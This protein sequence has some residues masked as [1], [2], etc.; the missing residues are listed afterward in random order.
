MRFYPFV[1]TGEVP[2]KEVRT[3]LNSITFNEERDEETCYGYCNDYQPHAVK[4][5]FDYNNGMLYDMRW[6]DAGNLGQVSIAKLGDMF[7]AGRFLFWTEDSRMHTAIDEKFYSYYTYDHSGG[8][9]ASREQSQACLSY[10]EMEQR[11]RS[12]RRLKLVGDNCSM[13]VNAEYM[14]ASSALNEPTFYPSA[15]MVLTNKGYT[16]H[17]YAGTER[18]AARLGGGGLY[19][20][21]PVIGND[22]ELQKKADILF[23][24]SI[25]QVNSRVLGENDLD[26]IMHNEYA[27]AEFGKWIEG[28]PYQVRA[29]VETEYWQFKDMVHSMLVDLNNGQEKEVYF[30]HS[31]H[32]GSASWIT[33]G[34]G[35]AVQ[36]IQYLPYGEPYI[37]QRAAG[38]T[39]S[40][41][42]R[43][44]G[45]ERDEET[46]YGYFGA[47]YM[48]HELMTM[49]LSVDPMADKYHSISPYAYCAWN[50]VKLVDPD[51]KEMTDFK[52]KKGNL[53]KHFEDGQDVSYVIKGTGA[54]EHFEYE[55]GDITAKNINYQ[56]GLA[57]QEQQSYN[58][59]NNELKENDAGQ[60]FCNYATQNVQQTVESIP[61]NDN[62]VTMGRANKMA[63]DMTTSDNYITVSQQEALQYAEQGY[64]VVSSWINPTGQSGHVATLSVGSNRGKG[65]EYANIGP[66]K[67]SGFTTFGASYGKNKRP[68]V[69][70]H[71]YMRSSC[72]PVQIIAS[73]PN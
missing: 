45:K 24:Q 23:K 18:V 51:G 49:W 29:D 37:D 44:T 68:H 34:G 26:C 32:L 7:E 66:A 65:R 2:C 4:R 13:D 57:I 71:V 54:H 8:S 33:E 58:M 43:F 31:D 25:E 67:Y 40:E 61:G 38:T 15:Y 19:A 59:Q 3:P 17:Y 56:T 10:A 16:K 55:S 5:M 63:N 30:Y 41:R 48:D 52:D 35:M 22:V 53:I 39:Y 60:T 72:K 73:K 6:D 11:R 36:H 46:G 14:N 70:H 1:F 69:Q 9:C 21:Y 27:R 42:F 62:V 50:P 12:Q 64:L 28:I 20:L 47:R